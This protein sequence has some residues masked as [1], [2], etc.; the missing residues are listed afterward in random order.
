MVTETP[1]HK[2]ATASRRKLRLTLAYD[3]ATTLFQKVFV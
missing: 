1:H 2:A 3:S